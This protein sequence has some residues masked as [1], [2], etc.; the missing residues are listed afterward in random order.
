M[1]QE[2]K[3]EAEKEAVKVSETRRPETKGQRKVR[4]RR[5]RK[6]RAVLRKITT[7]TVIVPVACFVASVALLI[8]AIV[9]LTQEEEYSEGVNEESDNYSF[10]DL[11]AW[12]LVICMFAIQYYCYIPPQMCITRTK[13]TCPCCV[14]I[15]DAVCDLDVGS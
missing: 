3:K 14:P 4:K 15:C 11:L 12:I 8:A 7:F 10:V 5:R 1:V 13:K 2:M 9:T 6:A